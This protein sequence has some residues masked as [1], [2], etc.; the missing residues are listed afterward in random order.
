MVILQN[1]YEAFSLKGHEKNCD[2]KPIHWQ[3]PEDILQS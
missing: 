1:P 2:D 3:T